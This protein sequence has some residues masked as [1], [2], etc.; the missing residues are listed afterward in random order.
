MIKSTPRAYPKAATQDADALSR[1]A[2]LG[3]AALAAGAAALMPLR[4][5]AQQKVAQ[6][7]AQYQDSPKN[8]QQCST[9]AHFQPPNSCQLV[10]GKISP[11]GWCA[12]YMKKS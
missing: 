6:S 4:A 5:H 10:E 11:N 1:R 7:A 9:C 12:L 8:G 3:G 2:L